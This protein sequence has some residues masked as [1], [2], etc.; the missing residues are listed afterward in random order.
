MHRTAVA[1]VLLGL[2]CSPPFVP[3]CR[4]STSSTLL[5]AELSAAT[6]RPNLELL[7]NKQL[8]LSWWSPAKGI[9]GPTA[10]VAVIA[11]DGSIVERYSVSVTAAATLG[12]Q[13]FFWT[14]DGIAVVHTHHESFDDPDG[15]EH[16]R[17]ELRFEHHSEAGARNIIDLPGTDCTDC[18]LSFVSRWLNGRLVVLYS[19]QGPTSPFETQFVTVSGSGTVEHRGT[20]DWLPGFVQAVQFAPD[21]NP[22]TDLLVVGTPTE[23]WLVDE[24]LARRSGPF[25]LP[26]S[27]TTKVDWNADASMVAVGWSQ[28]PRFDLLLQVFD[29]AGNTIF[30]A[31]RI[32]HAVSVESLAI[33]ERL[34]GIAFFDDAHQETLSVTAEGKGKIGGDIGLRRLP[35]GTQETLI[36]PEDDGFTY[37]EVVR[38]IVLSRIACTQ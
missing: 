6:S 38:S 15:T 5:A 19:Q 26:F 31:Q 20:L 29:R 37:V 13:R 24:T 32:S 34:F 28:P 33:G 25:G 27:Q 12:P 1:F 36:V 35:N 8:R 2:G 7:P 4:V 3:P 22:R 14:G 21:W 11:T 23:F 17:S 16:R 9:E 18:D 10:E 30:Q